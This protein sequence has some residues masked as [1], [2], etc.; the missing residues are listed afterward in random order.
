[1]YLIRHRNFANGVRGGYLVRQD[2]PDDA[3]PK[4]IIPIPEAY[5]HLFVDLEV[6]HSSGI[7]VSCKYPTYQLT[8]MMG[9]KL[10]DWCANKRVKHRS[11]LEQQYSSILQVMQEVF[12]TSTYFEFGRPRFINAQNDKGAS[13]LYIF[14]FDKVPT[15]LLDPDRVRGSTITEIG[16]RIYGCVKDVMEP[17]VGS[18]PLYCCDMSPTITCDSSN[19][20]VDYIAAGRHNFLGGQSESQEVVKQATGS[21]KRYVF[22]GDRGY[23]TQNPNAHRKSYGRTHL[24]AR[25]DFAAQLCLTGTYSNSSYSTG[26]PPRTLTINGLVEA[27]VGR[28]WNV[29]CERIKRELSKLRR[30][31]KRLTKGEFEN[32][33]SLLYRQSSRQHYA[34]PVAV[35]LTVTSNDRGSFTLRRGVYTDKP[36]RV[37]SQ[38]LVHAHLRAAT[39]NLKDRTTAMAR[40][41]KAIE[42]E[43]WC[44]QC[45][46]VLSAWGERKNMN[47]EYPFNVESLCS[48]VGD[49]LHE[50]VELPKSLNTKEMQTALSNAKKEY[51]RYV[52]ESAAVALQ[53]LQI[54]GGDAAG[55]R[56]TAE[57]A[58]QALAI[59][60]GNFKN[61]EL[62][63]IESQLGYAIY[64]ALGE[65]AQ[66]KIY[67][68]ICWVKQRERINRKRRARNN[69]R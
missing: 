31:S 34:D 13:H 15:L 36:S 10:S 50:L 6:E 17:G 52:K 41:R 40:L 8:A 9:F 61:G 2:V 64:Q 54:G 37:G 25:V 59:S 1:M 62:K 46:D 53:L 60:F 65:A 24:Y 68:S 44:R 16:D 42:A 21:G 58:K 63:Q 20:R 3:E 14:A 66:R 39:R 57:F 18:V 38:E 48:D 4:D 35:G 43:G 11:G 32:Q 33:V 27:D 23:V 55:R 49:I 19:C 28:Y 26:T 69:G 47:F 5:S 12:R 29:T 7:L 51:S 30:P 45:W 56:I 67:D 22:P